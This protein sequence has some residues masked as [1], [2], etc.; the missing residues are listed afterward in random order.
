MPVSAKW[1][2]LPEFH[3]SMKVHTVSLVPFPGS[4][5]N[6]RGLRKKLTQIAQMRWIVC[7]EGIQST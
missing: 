7:E 1:L 4:G 2:F 5:C 6:T 3:D